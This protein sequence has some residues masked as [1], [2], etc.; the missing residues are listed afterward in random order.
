MRRLV[1]DD[2]PSTVVQVQLVKDRPSWS[3]AGVAGAAMTRRTWRVSED[4][5][6]HGSFVAPLNL[7]LGHSSH[8]PPLASLD[9]SLDILEELA[10]L[11]RRL[12]VLLPFSGSVLCPPVL[13]VVEP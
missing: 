9:A 4:F 3:S 11:A 7:G 2:E 5:C 13:R 6:A 8:N 10:V 1:G 12:A